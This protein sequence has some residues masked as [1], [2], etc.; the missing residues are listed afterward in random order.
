MPQSILSPSGQC[1]LYQLF[2]FEAPEPTKSAELGIH[3]YNDNWAGTQLSFRWQKRETDRLLWMLGTET[4]RSGCYPSKKAM[5]TLAP[6]CQSQAVTILNLSFYSAFENIKG[7]KPRTSLMMNT[8]KINKTCTN[9]TCKQRAEEAQ[10]SKL[11]LLLVST[12]V[13]RDWTR[14]KARIAACF[15][16]R[17]QGC[18]G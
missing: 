1:A 9:K 12:D 18:N 6:S 3:M 5:Q 4:Q 13:P 10:P 16:E 14:R 8:E 17:F 7:I 11:G 2:I 15:P